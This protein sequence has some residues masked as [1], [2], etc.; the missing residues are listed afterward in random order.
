M[1]DVLVLVS[2]SEADITFDTRGQDHR[3]GDGFYAWYEGVHEKVTGMHYN[4][5]TKG[6]VTLGNFSCKLCHNFVAPL[7]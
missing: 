2:N 5:T 4:I 7:R 3:R 6:A 1:G